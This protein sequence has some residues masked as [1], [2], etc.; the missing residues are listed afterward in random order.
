VIEIGYGM[1][2]AR[3]TEPPG[4]VRPATI[5]I[6]DV[7]GKHSLQVSLTEDQYPSVSSVL[8]V[9]TNRSAK[10]F[11]LG[12]RGGI[13]TTSM[14]YAVPK[15]NAGSVA[16]CVSVAVRLRAGRVARGNLTPG[17]PQIRT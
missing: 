12:P 5:V 17:L 11:A 15:G 7:L 2:R 3:R 8:A 16:W 9:S 14:P 13:F 4:T 10:Q 6:P 1:I